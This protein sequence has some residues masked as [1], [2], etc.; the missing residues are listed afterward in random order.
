M[1]ST[2]IVQ[3]NLKGSHGV[4]V[5][6]PTAYD[7]C[8]ELAALQMGFWVTGT[9]GS[10]VNYRSAKEIVKEHLLQAFISSILLNSCR[11]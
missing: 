11:C 6:H 1:I 5:V 4:L 7:G 3:G 2:N 10:D 8:V 9:S